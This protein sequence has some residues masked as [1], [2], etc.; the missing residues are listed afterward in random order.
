MTP[1]DL[2]RPSRRHLLQAG[3]GLGALLLLAPAMALA[4][5][6]GERR[7]SFHHLH[8][9]E[10]STVTYWADGTYVDEELR[11]V[12]HLLRDF[13]TGEVH[14]IDPG[15]LDLLYLTRRRIGSDRPFQIISGYRSPQ[16]NRMLRRHSSG[17]AKH[18]LHMEGM[19]IDIHLP[20]TRL[21]DLRKAAMSLKGGGVGYYPASSFV[22]VD[23]GRVRYW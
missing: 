9:G 5:R 20:G 17:V 23:T 4:R 10:S 7:L 22:H 2:A 15:L 3:I 16:T 19:A 21:A 14:A 11:A 13:R 1:D 6:P 12:N 8:T 18:S